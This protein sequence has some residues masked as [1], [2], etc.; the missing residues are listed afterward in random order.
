MH[1]NMK[2][3]NKKTGSPVVIAEEEK[4]EIL[5]DT[6]I[7]NEEQHTRHTLFIQMCKDAKEQRDQNYDFFDGMTYEEDYYANQKAANAYLRPKLNDDE[8][9]VATGATEKKLEVLSNNIL[10]MNI[11]EEVVAYDDA[12][13]ELKDLGQ[14]MMDAVKRTCD[15]EKD[16]DFWQSWLRELLTQRLVCFEEIDEYQIYNNRRKI[17]LS[18]EGYDKKVITVNKE[19]VHHKPR[20]RLISGLRIYFG[21]IFVPARSFQTDQPYI[22]VYAQR[23]YTATKQIYGKWSRW[24]Y[25]QSGKNQNESSPAYYRMEDVS[26]NN[27]EEI[28]IIDPVNGEYYVILNGVPMLEEST[29]LWYEVLPDR[30]Y[31]FDIKTIKEV[32]SEFIYGKPPVAS[33][34][35]FQALTEE[36]IRN[37]IIKWRQSFAPAL[38]VSSD[39]AH[40][41]SKDIFQAGAVTQGLTPDDVFLINPENKGVTQSEFNMYELINQETEKFLG[42]GGDLA[43]GIAPTGEQT[44]EEIQTLQA[45][46]VKNLGHIV[47]A[48]MRV[49]RDAPYLRIYN[50]LENFVKPVR[51]YVNPISDVISDVYE[52]FT[53]N[54]ATFSDGKRGKKIVQFTDRNM[55]PLEKDAIFGFELQEEKAGRPVRFR[56]INIKA[57]AK[58]NVFWH[59]VVNQQRREGSALDRIMFQDQLNQAKALSEI[60]GRPISDAKPIEEFAQRWQAPG[61]FKEATAQQPGQAPEGAEDLAKKI[62]ET[63]KRTLAGSQATEGPRG[64]AQRPSLTQLQKN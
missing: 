10:S 42:A 6:L 9:R 3:T 4:N 46:A 40:L 47:A 1:Y 50:I 36:G 8:V 32:D 2:E 62:G 20:K 51:K 57:L 56:A 45:N 53:V 59:V 55:T 22:C 43:S 39:N 38:G 54:N 19:R 61:W 17:A 58:I 12:D 33:A 30:R 16:E 5:E 23:S 7:L 14:D 21:D 64:A 31:T 24:K 63:E 34:K 29:P 28:R 25:V 41:I 13:N 44:A 35:M 48:Y 26:E 49:R 18:P 11:G 60:T 37:M 15:M 52:K 27:V